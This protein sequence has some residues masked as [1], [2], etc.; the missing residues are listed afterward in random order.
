MP[1]IVDLHLLSMLR[2]SLLLGETPMYDNGYRYQRTFTHH[3]E[4][5]QRTKA[6]DRE[7]SRPA[8]IAKLPDTSSLAAIVDNTSGQEICTGVI[9]TRNYLL[10]TVEALLAKRCNGSKGM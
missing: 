6:F 9:V 7:Y 10:T 2:H 8:S 5:V 1:G 4:A 3:R